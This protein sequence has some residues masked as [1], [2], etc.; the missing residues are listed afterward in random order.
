M[1]KSLHFLPCL[2][3]V[4]GFWSCGGPQTPHAPLSQYL[5]ANWEF[6][7]LEDKDWLPAEVPGCVQ[8]DLF[9]AGK[10][11]DPLAYDFDLAHRDLEKK[12]WE[13][14]LVFNPP[15]QFLEREEL[16]LL[17][18]GLD[19]YA[20]VRLNDSLILRADNMF[21]SWEIPVKTIIKEGYNELRIRFKPP[22]MYHQQRW[23]DRPYTLPAGNDAAEEK[24]SVYSRKAAFQFGW[25]WGPRLVT[26][27]IWRPVQLKAWDRAQMKD[28]FIKQVTLG[29]DSARLQANFELSSNRVQPARV[30]ILNQ[31]NDSLLLDEII[32]LREGHNDLRRNFTIVNP[33]L[34]WPRGYGDQKLYPLQARLFIGEHEVDSR[35]YSLGL[36]TIE[37][38]QEE[39]E[40]GESFFFKVNEQRIF[41]K[42][43]N[44]IPNSPILS[45]SSDSLYQR[46]IRDALRSNMN[47]LRVWAGGIYENDRFY[48]L[49]DS[50]GIL[51]WQDLMFANIPP[52]DA[53]FT[54]NA[55]EEVRENVKRLRVH[56]SLALWCGN[57]ELEVAWFN[58]GWQK[59]HEYSEGDSARIWDNYLQ[60][61]HES[62]PEELASLHKQGAYVATSPLSN[63]GKLENFNIGTNHYWGVWHGEED[64]EGLEIN[65]P[66]FM[67]EYGMQSLP[68]LKTAQSA[69]GESFSVEDLAQ[70]QKSYKGNRLLKDYIERYFPTPKNAEAFVYLSQLTQALA[71][72][73]AIQAH[74]SRQP[75]CMGT[76]YWQFNDCWPGISWSGRDVFGRWKAMQ[77]KVR[78]GYKDLAVFIEEAD[79][80]LKVITVNDGGLPVQKKIAVALMDLTGKAL[81]EE[82]LSAS[83]LPG[84]STVQDYTRQGILKGSNPKNAVLRV[85]LLDLDGKILMEDLHFFV[86]PKNLG[87]R[88]PGLIVKLVSGDAKEALLEVEGKAFAKGVQI[89]SA[90]R[91]IWLEDNYF[92]FIPGKSNQ[93]RVEIRDSK[94]PLSFEDLQIFSLYEMT[95]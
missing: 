25:D 22:L 55:L 85:Q 67:S 11:S 27:G 81:F 61:F 79:S 7:A 41:A 33:E 39:D 42:G 84:A 24:I 2:L 46:L 59:E 87:L 18:E 58:W 73:I 28:L 15:A 44:Y 3:L 23:Q 89:S 53:A 91:E 5:H 72:E 49:C 75:F 92:D 29:R 77:Y 37:L 30:Q 62:I 6:K 38:I 1:K 88:N 16:H 47:M 26:N 48:E 50:A 4:L 93:I 76:L 35:S 19:T 90:D 12:E 20:E 45:R 17:F 43:A 52:D 36:R 68:E 80:K 66:R 34:W 95:R 63:W 56:P 70:L 60:L 94:G 10:I 83:L 57:N 32:H 40:A 8:E 21:R 74:R 54:E 82:T 71:V 64:F 31:E 13:Y 65:V 78:E 86:K 69:L 14:R 9:R 51:V